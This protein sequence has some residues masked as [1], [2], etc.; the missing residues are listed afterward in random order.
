MEVY[1][2]TDS[3]NLSPI[4]VHSKKKWKSNVNEK[5]NVIKYY[6]EIGSKDTLISRINE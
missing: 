1:Q 4:D 5:R 2:E 3:S 6:S